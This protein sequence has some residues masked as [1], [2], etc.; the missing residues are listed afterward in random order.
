LFGLVSIDAENLDQLLPDGTDYKL[1]KLNK[2]EQAVMSAWLHAGGLLECFFAHESRL[3]FH[4]CADS[5]FSMKNAVIALS[6]CG[7]HA[8]IAVE[9]DD[10][11]II[12]PFLSECGRFSVDPVDAYGMSI[13]DARELIRINTRI[14]NYAYSH[15]RVFETGA[16]YAQVL[17]E[18]YASQLRN[19]V[20]S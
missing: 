18:D 9:I 5:T 3:E 15:N 10:M 6:E 16:E 2:D 12:N 7:Q 8:A 11:A 1:P 13:A 4:V 14:H 19:E 20:R 17:V